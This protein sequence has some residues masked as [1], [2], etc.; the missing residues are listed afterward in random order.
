MKTLT[1]QPTKVYQLAAEE[2]IE[3]I[4]ELGF[5]SEIKVDYKELVDKLTQIIRKNVEEKSNKNDE[6]IVSFPSNWGWG[7]KNFPE[8]SEDN[9]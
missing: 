1:S 6:T 3:T 8:W 7:I 5:T 9:K 2:I 4:S